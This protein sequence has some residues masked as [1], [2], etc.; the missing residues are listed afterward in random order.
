MF[1][2]QGRNDISPIA[3]VSV[4]HIYGKYTI[5]LVQIGGFT[6]YRI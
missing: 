2:H 4:A 5:A 3:C 1:Y 6:E